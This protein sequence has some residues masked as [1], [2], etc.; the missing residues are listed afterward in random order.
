M[1]SPRSGNADGRV[2][3]PGR[4]EQTKLRLIVPIG[5][6]TNG[7]VRV[8]ARRGFIDERRDESRAVDR[9]DMATSLHQACSSSI[10]RQPGPGAL[11]PR[12]LLG[13]ACDWPDWPLEVEPLGTAANEAPGSGPPGSAGAGASPQWSVPASGVHATA[14]QLRLCFPCLLL[15]FDLIKGAASSPFPHPSSASTTT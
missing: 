7:R 10:Q 12:S 4:S 2:Q 11:H 13:A 5:A 15:G 8:V 14:G 3:T 1:P 6:S 9:P